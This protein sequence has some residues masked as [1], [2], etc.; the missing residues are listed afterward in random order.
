MALVHC[1]F[2]SQV[3]GLMTTMSVLLPDPPPGEGNQRAAVK[4]FPTLYLLHGR[5]DDHSAWQRR[6]ALERYVEGLNLA[7]VMP[8]VGRSYYTDTQTG[9]RYW[10]FISEEVP[11]MARHFF[12]L[13]KR[14]EENYLAG[15]SMG[16]YG[17][18]KLALSYPHRYAA[19]ASLSGALD[20]VRLTGTELEAGQHELVHVFGDPQT[21][22]GSMNDLF[23]LAESAHENAPHE[24][25]QLYQWCGTEDFLYLDNRRFRKHLDTLG[26]ALDYDEG[27]G[28]HEWACW[29]AQIQRVLGWLPGVERSARI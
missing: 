27:P 14:R 7:V 16:G 18:F 21:L 8:E 26:I 17:A 5:S 24:L 9:Q 3:L 4:P 1:Q 11:M 12:P 10:A 19:A 22:S 13:S 25:P 2:Y 15:L 28:G 20:V 6:T 29:D 23:A